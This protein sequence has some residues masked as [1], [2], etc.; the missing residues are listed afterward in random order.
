MLNPIMQ[1]HPRHAHGKGP[2]SS[3]SCLLALL[4]AC[5]TADAKPG[6]EPGVP[7]PVYAEMPWSSLRPTQMEI[8]AAYADLKTSDQALLAQPIGIREKA[9]AKTVPVVLGPDGKAY[10]LDRHHWA[11]AVHQ[12]ALRERESA[13]KADQV[14]L[15]VEVVA[16]FSR[17]GSTWETFAEHLFAHQV[18]YFTPAVRRKF[19]LVISSDGKWSEIPLA[20]KVRLYRDHLPRDFNGLGDNP[21]RSVVGVAIKELQF[22]ASKQLINYAQFYLAELLAPRLRREQFVTE[23]GISRVAIERVKRLIVTDGEVRAR[24]WRMIRPGAE[25]VATRRS[26]LQQMNLH[27]RAIGLRNLRETAPPRARAK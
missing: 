2:V 7:G 8:G 16:D 1:L 4:L 17:P 6:V 13:K 23:R 15:R 19:K 22:K 25:A 18:G 10:V 14:K 21:L 3:F 24:L 11:T 9:L 5:A 26:M 20:D 27:R 12:V